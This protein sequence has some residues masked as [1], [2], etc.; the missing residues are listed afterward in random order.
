MPAMGGQQ[1]L[2][3]TNRHA[4]FLS[5]RYGMNSSP[6]QL[7]RLPVGKNTIRANTHTCT[8]NTRPEAPQQPQAT[9]L[10]GVGNMSRALKF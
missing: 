5:Y 8:W 3:Q 4:T 1:D 10:L 6:L 9:Y 7:L 2:Y